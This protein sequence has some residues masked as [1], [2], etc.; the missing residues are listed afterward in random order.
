MVCYIGNMPIALVA[1][2]ILILVLVVMLVAPLNETSG[3]IEWI[4]NL[5]TLRSILLKLY[6]ERGVGSVTSGEW[7]QHEECVAVS[8]FSMS[9]V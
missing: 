7:K 4:E 3:I 2:A 1:R 6:Q 8:K 5:A 9:L